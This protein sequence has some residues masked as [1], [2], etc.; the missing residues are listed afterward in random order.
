[1]SKTIRV[2]DEAHRDISE[3]QRK[4]ETL[5]E[6]VARLIQ[7]YKGLAGLSGVVGGVKEYG[8]FQDTRRQLQKTPQR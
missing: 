6:T 5:G 1:M 3:I 4:H 8:E 2:S 7:V